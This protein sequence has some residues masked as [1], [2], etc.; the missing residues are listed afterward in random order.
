MPV[1]VVCLNSALDVTYET[2]GFAVDATNRVTRVV[3]R[4]G[5]KGVNVAR[6]L[7]ALGTDVLLLGLAGGAAGAA[8][9]AELDRDGV[10]HALTPIGAETRS[11]VTI[12]DGQVAT[13]LAE[14]GPSVTDGE[15][16]AFRDGYAAVSADAVVLSG[17]LPPGLPVTAYAELA[18]TARAPVVLD[19]AGPALAAA[20]AERPTLVKP[21]ATEAAEA[22]GDP[23]DA[24]AAARALVSRGA[25]NAVVTCGADGLVALLD[26]RPWRARAAEQVAGNPTGAGDALAA[27][28]A[29]S[30]VARTPWPDA[31]ADAV[32]LAAGAVAVPH[33][34]EVDAAVAERVRKTV[35]VTPA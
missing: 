10:P 12:V 28:L 29:R 20:L 5:G 19:A 31:L 24:A 32:A 15:W 18:A 35:E 13:V 27:S 8:I 26:G 17:S 14:P 11:T 3:R 1:V 34:G 9:R 33:A 23:V 21:N 30:L 22:L 6:V 2:P 4:A 16:R 7:H 25:R